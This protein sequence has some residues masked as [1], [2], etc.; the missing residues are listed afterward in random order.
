MMKNNK[1][2]VTIGAIP[3][4]YRLSLS[5]EEQ[6]VWLCNYTLTTIIPAIND[7]AETLEEVIALYEELKEEI[8]QIDLT[9]YYTKTEV[10]DLLS[11][12]ADKSEIP[13]LNNYYTKSETN[14]QINTSLS[15]YATITYVDGLVGD[16]NSVLDTINGEVI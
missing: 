2:C 9:N 12:K 4:S 15:G 7:N 14:A 5:Y 8:E 13:D 1:C 10:N 11:N 6:I 16:I 3:T